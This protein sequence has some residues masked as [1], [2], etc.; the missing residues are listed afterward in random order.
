MVHL[1]GIASITPPFGLNLF[2]LKATLP[3]SDMKEIFG[4]TFPFF[5]ASVI[6]LV[7]YTAFPQLSLW[8]P[9]LM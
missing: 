4:G 2:I 3:D 8:L 6:V 1:I 9:S 5:I 7:I